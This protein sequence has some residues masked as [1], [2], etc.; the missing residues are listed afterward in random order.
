M[1]TIAATV[2]VP[3]AR[4]GPAETFLINASLSTNHVS[5]ST[6]I[7]FVVSPIVIIVAFLAL[8][9]AKA[10][11]I[12]LPSLGNNDVADRQMLREVPDEHIH[13]HELPPT[14]VADIEQK[15][16]EIVPSGPPDAPILTTT[17]VWTAIQSAR[18]IAIPDN[19]AIKDYRAKYE[20]EA[21]WVSKILSRA[22]PYIG[23]VVEQLDSRFLPIE[24]ALLP[25]IE[26]GYLP[27]VI[28]AGNAAGIWQI[29]PIT[30][31][32]IGIERNQ[33]YDGRTDIS[34][35][36][37]AAIDYLSYLNAE[38]N[39]DWLLTLAAYNAGPGRVRTA[40]K[41][42]RKNDKPTDYWSLDLPRETKNYVPKFLALL[43]ALRDADNSALTVPKV[44]IGSAF[45]LVD[46]GV[47]VSIDKVAAFS[48]LSESELMRLNAG[49]VHGVTPPKGPHVLY[50]PRSDAKTFVESIQQ[51]GKQK[52]YSLPLTHTVVAGDSISSIALQYGITQSRLKN[53]NSIDGSRIMIGQKLAVLDNAGLS[54][55]RTVPA[56]SGETLEYV[57]SI[58]DTLSDI[59]SKFS[60][61]LRDITDQNGEALKSDVIHPGERLSII[62]GS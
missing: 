51:A 13:D 59:A 38:F 23:H 32:E 47:R 43:D 19:Q 34:T 26:S 39:G 3:P 40:I 18:R 44:A 24:L 54:D 17:N 48:S 6:S 4:L 58:G 37:T 35:S 57:V 41:K 16:T 33:W 42:N 45:K 2:T 31:R 46:V 28:S 25:A 29:V 21:L 9:G 12:A 52:L 53:M 36:T 62:T 30:A 60:V 7:A 11:G 8:N 61:R 14:E 5:P 20:S 50:V 27:D 56:G 49:L 55:N 10:Q 1:R 15:A 22:S